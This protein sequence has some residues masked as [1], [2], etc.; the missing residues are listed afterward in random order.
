MCYL[1]TESHALLIAIVV[2]LLHNLMVCLQ[3]NHDFEHTQ[4]PPFRQCTKLSCG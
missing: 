3:K 2:G 1:H 4:K